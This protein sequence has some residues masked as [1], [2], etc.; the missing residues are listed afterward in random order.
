MLNLLY[1]N[2]STDFILSPKSVILS[3][4]NICIFFYQVRKIPTRFPQSEN[5]F[6]EGMEKGWEFPYWRI[7]RYR[8]ETF[9]RLFLFHVQQVETFLSFLTAVNFMTLSSI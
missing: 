4:N 9:S 6:L 7:P 8:L 3:K 1:G 5:F 2:Q